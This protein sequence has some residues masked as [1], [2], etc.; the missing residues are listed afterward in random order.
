MDSPGTV[1]LIAGVALIIG[2]IVTPLV[3]NWFARKGQPTQ[4]A[5]DRKMAAETDSLVARNL[6]NEI[7]R[8]DKELRDNR[9]ETDVLRTEVRQ[10]RDEVEKRPTRQELLDDNGK[11]RKQLIDLGAVPENGK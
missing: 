7:K 5:Q 8:L 3:S 1:A 6:E 10:L 9:L 2:G 4:T 11:L